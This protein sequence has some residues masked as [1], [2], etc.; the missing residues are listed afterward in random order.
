MLVKYNSIAYDLD[1]AKIYFEIRQSITLI[2][3]AIGESKSVILRLKMTT[4][5]TSGM[6]K[7]VGCRKTTKP[8]ENICLC[9][10]EKEQTILLARWSQTLP[11]ILVLRLAHRHFLEKHFLTIKRILW[12]LGLKALYLHSISTPLSGMI[13]FV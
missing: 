7:H 13:K 2:A 1:R 4:E 10:S 3:S 12:L 5:G 11:A 9:S 8:H 6:L